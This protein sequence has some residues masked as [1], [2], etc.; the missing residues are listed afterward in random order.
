MKIIDAH[1]HYCQQAIPGKS[2]IENMD[3]CNVEKSNDLSGVGS[4]QR[5]E[6]GRYFS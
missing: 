4:G 5:T 6:N 2:I 3:A 1:I